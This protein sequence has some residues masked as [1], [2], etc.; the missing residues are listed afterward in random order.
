MIDIIPEL[1]K[2]FSDEGMELIPEDA[3]DSS[4]QFPCITYRESENTDAS[5]GDN[6]GYSSIAYSIQIWSYSMSEISVLSG[7]ID[8][9]MKKYKFTRFMGDI[10]TVDG[11]HRKILGYRKI[12]KESF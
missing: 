10:Q 3:A 6:M 2:A 12:I 8:M 1:R 5:V 9:L 11:L 4:V 7:K